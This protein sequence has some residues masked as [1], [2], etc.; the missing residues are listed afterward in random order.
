MRQASE[1]QEL[2][3]WEPWNKKMPSL[4]LLPTSTIPYPE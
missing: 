4:H 1:G 2:V 3:F